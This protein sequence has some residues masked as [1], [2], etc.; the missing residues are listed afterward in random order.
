MIKRIGDEEYALI[1]N[2]DIFDQTIDEITKDD[3]KLFIDTNIIYLLYEMYQTNGYSR[4]F[5][6]VIRKHH[7]DGC[8]DEIIHYL[9]PGREKLEKLLKNKN[10]I[11]I[12]QCQNELNSEQIKGQLERDLN[13][14][15]W[16]N[17][18]KRQKIVNYVSSILKIIKRATCNDDYSAYRNVYP[19]NLQEDLSYKNILKKVIISAKEEFPKNLLSLINKADRFGHLEKIND[20]TCKSDSLNTLQNLLKNEYSSFGKLKGVIGPS[21]LG[22]KLR[23]K[24]TYEESALV[25]WFSE[26]LNSQEKNPETDLALD[27]A[28]EVYNGRWLTDLN[29]ITN[30]VRQSQLD[31]GKQVLSMTKDKDSFYIL[32]RFCS[33]FNNIEPFNIK[34]IYVYLP[35][36]YSHYPKPLDRLRIKS[37]IFTANEGN[38]YTKS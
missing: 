21:I 23:K 8:A 36:M 32:K 19:N 27:A 16:S 12:P 25:Y 4:K 33:D 29:L 11:I 18:I 5:C 37:H 22:L 10:T 15:K 38:K 26:K 7:E 9:K 6:S 35:N 3:K 34:L 30:S 14:L 20:G 13:A 17:V 28:F 1:E 31:K 24:L 2:W